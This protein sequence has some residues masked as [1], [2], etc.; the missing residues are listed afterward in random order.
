MT[1]QLSV[2]R[3]F[4]ALEGQYDARMRDVHGNASVGVGSLEADRL[5]PEEA[6]ALEEALR[7]VRRQADMT[8]VAG[9]RWHMQHV[10]GRLADVLRRLAP[11]GPR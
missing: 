3:L 5:T 9:V 4:I 6:S 11:E 8:N 10:A 2:L 1:L 7:L